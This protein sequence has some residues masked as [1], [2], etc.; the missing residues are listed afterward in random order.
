MTL[1]SKL[2]LSNQII[3]AIKSA[4][5]KWHRG[6]GVYVRVEQQSLAVRRDHLTGTTTDIVR[7]DDRL[8]TGLIGGR[9]SGGLLLRKEQHQSVGTQA[10]L[11]APNP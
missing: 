4:Q 5:L 1:E 9:R 7:H 3:P 8:E 11:R 6:R 10:N 2:F